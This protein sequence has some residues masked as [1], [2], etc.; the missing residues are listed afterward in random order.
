MWKDWPPQGV[1]DTSFFSVAAAHSV[2]PLPLTSCSPDPV[3]IS[4]TSAMLYY[5]K[6]LSEW[7]E[8]PTMW[9]GISNSEKLNCQ[10]CG[11]KQS[12]NFLCIT[13]LRHCHIDSITNIKK[14]IIREGHRLAC[15]IHLFSVLNPTQI[16]EE[17]WVGVM[18]NNKHC[19]LCPV[20]LKIYAQRISCTGIS[21][22][23][24]FFVQALFS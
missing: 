4:V 20:V 17:K 3:K 9:T 23:F 6:T 10:M 24:I 14:K 12:N 16:W 5:L 7:V 2:L 11:K 1:P 18:R 15:S 21:V 8:A 13:M 22:F 19:K